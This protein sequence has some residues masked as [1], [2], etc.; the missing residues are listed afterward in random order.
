MVA[1]VEDGNQM[2]QFQEYD[3]LILL[4]SFF[5]PQVSKHLEFD[6]RRRGEGTSLWI[7]FRDH[8]DDE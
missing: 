5:A 4:S 3:V 8:W 7:N 6:K 1:G 2:L